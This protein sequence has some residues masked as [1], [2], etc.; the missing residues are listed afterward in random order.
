MNDPAA[1]LAVIRKIL[2]DQGLDG[3]I[4]PGA[5]DVLGDYIN[6][7]ERERRLRWISGASVFAATAIIL[8]DRAI[9]V[10]EARYRTV[11]PGTLDR[12]LWQ[13]VLSPGADPGPTLR[14]LPSGL[15]LGYDPRQHAAGGRAAMAANLARAGC[16][17][18]PVPANPVDLAWTDRPAASAS[19]A[20]LHDI[21]F[22]GEASDAKRAR[23]AAQLRAD[24]LTGAVLADPLSVC[25]LLNLRGGDARTTPML[26]ARALLHADGAVTLFADPAKLGMDLGEAV[27]VAPEAGFAP[28]L[29][30]RTAGEA[31]LVDPQAGCFIADRLQAAGALVVAET[32]PCRI[33]RAVKN[34]VELAG[35]RAAQLRDGVAV[36]EWLAWLAANAPSAGLGEFRA[37][38]M[39]SEFRARQAM[40]QGPSFSTI[41]PAGP[42]GAVP[43]YVAAE[44]ADRVLQDGDLFLCDSG[45]QYLDGTTDI[46]RAVAI[47]TPSALARHDYTLVLKAHIALATLRFPAGTS[48]QQL[49][50]VARAPLWREG[51]DYWHGTSH[52]VGSFL[53]VHDPP[54][55]LARNE[56]AAPLLPGMVMSIE[57]GFYRPGHHGIRLENLVEV[58]DAGAGEDGTPFLGFSPLT[59]VPFDPALIQTSL[60]TEAERAWLAAYTETVWTELQALLSPPARALLHAARP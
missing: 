40:F 27:S 4:L 25:W 30:E 22:A 17:L 58:I 23:I 42:N 60:L 34:P 39:L 59:R 50:A 49:D 45:G 10:A 6:T 57:P 47:G 15:R 7:P 31:W 1:R 37:A 32:D 56:S 53:S 12:T 28:A 54:P 26:R 41:S 46:T 36:V 51:R 5:D 52:G 19:P 9:L 43:H 55:S 33:A 3:L 8:Q 16:A 44:G 24:K 20:W 38:A 29:S 18:A 13:V 2:Q 21:A 48:G 35:M 11:L 14:A